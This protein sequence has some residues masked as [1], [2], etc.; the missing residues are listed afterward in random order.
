MFENLFLGVNNLFPP[1]YCDSVN[2]IVI[3]NA[4]LALGYDVETT[5]VLIVFSKNNLKLSRFSR[6]TILN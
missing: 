3:P 1:P 5:G 4:V 2:L 6:R